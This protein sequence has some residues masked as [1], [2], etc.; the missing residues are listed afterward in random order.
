MTYSIIA[1]DPM[2]GEIG[3]AVQSRYF[4][5]GTVVPWAEAG[6]GAVATQS[7]VDPSYGPLGLELMRRG[8]SAP[9]ALRFLVAA[10]PGAAY[11]QVAMIDATGRVAVHTGEQCLEEAGHA[12]GEQVAAQA[13]LMARNTVWRAMLDAFVRAEDDLATRLL[14]ALDAAEAEG[15]DRRGKQSAAMLIVRARSTGKLWVDRVVDVRV[16]DHV[17]PVNELRRLVEI[18]RDYRGRVQERKTLMDVLKV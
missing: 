13:N 17:D 1:R 8:H 11:R 7:F 16:E 3:V 2:T 4:S 18:H 5:V 15:G 10:D 14:A 9:E 12:I 6:V